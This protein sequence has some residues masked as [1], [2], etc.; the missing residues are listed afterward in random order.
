[1]TP[2]PDAPQQARS[3][4]RDNGLPWPPLPEP[5][6]GRLAPRGEFVFATRELPAPPYDIG[7]YIDEFIERPGTPPYAIAGFDGHGTNSWAV[8]CYLVEDGLGLFIQLP[9]GG[10]FMA[11]EDTRPPIERMFEWAGQHLRPMLQACRREGRIP[12]GWRLLVATRL[13]DDPV[14]AWIAPAG[15]RQGPVQWQEA[16]TLEAALDGLLAGRVHLA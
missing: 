13:D 10:A 15:Q 8:H 9:W 3:V 7:H 16:G 12:P 4:F 5:L 1:M 6:A 11:P 2:A 14:W